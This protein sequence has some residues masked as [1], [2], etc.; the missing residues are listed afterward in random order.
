MAGLGRILSALG[1]LL[2]GFA[3]TALAGPVNIRA[4]LDSTDP[5]ETMTIEWFGVTDDLSTPGQ[6]FLTRDSTVDA[7]NNYDGFP[8]PG[9][10]FTAFCLEPLDPLMV[11]ELSSFMVMDIGM[12]TN[13]DILREFWGRFHGSLGGGTERAAFQLG[14]WEIVYDGSSLGN[15]DL[16]MDNFKAMDN[17]TAL[18]MDI[19]TQANTWLAALDGDSSFFAAGLKNLTYSGPHLDGQ[20]ILIQSVPLPGAAALGLVGLSLSGLARLRSRRRLKSGEI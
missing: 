12:T 20:N 6:L 11:G 7:G 17:G 13:D 5:H 16:T 18:G 4:T 14:V 19:I 1:V 2:S 3:G 10:A 8:A 9:S 15:L